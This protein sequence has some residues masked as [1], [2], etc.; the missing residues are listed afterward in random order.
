MHERLYRHSKR[1]LTTKFLIRAQDIIILSEYTGWQYSELM[2]LGIRKLY[3]W[4][5]EAIKWHNKKVKAQS[6]GQTT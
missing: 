2:N 4:I 6:G 5:N 1:I 3:Y